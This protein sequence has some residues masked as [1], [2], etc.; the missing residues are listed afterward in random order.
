MTPL[1]SSDAAF[2]RLTVPH[3]ELYLLRTLDLGSPADDVLQRLI[4]ETPWRHESVTVWGKTYPQPRLIAWYGD[5]GTT[6][7]YSKLTLEPRPWTALL[8]DLK[9]RVEAA[10]GEAFNSVLVNY[11]RDG[12]DRMGFHSDDEPELGP[13]P[14]LASLSLGEE[15]IFILRSRRDKSVKP[16]RILLPSGSLLL[17]KGE[18]QTNWQH[19][20]DRETRANGPRI[21]L[22][23]RYVIGSDRRSN[24][25]S[26][27]S[28]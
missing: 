25:V 24:P 12:N 9:S 21:N 17:M 6:Y 7:T 27:V 26:G 10:S 14:T 18:T 11:Y 1:F 15:R 16:V 5:E 3:A 4:T 19:G 2:E 28:T 20:I 22:T 23:F 8:A 13:N